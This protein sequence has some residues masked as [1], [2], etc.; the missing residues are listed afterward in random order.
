MPIKASGSSGES[1][2]VEVASSA[3]TYRIYYSSSVLHPTAQPNQALRQKET[4]PLAWTR[5]EDLLG[6]EVDQ[7]VKRGSSLR[8]VRRDLQSLNVPFFVI[9][10]PFENVVT[11]LKRC[12]LVE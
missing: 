2:L 12:D 1:S 9:T 5:F 3:F 8:E 4:R 6:T 7:P 11:V 10:V